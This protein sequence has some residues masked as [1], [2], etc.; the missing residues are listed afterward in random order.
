MKTKNQLFM[1]VVL[2]TIIFGCNQNNFTINGRI[3]NMS[4]GKMVLSYSHLNGLYQNDTVQ[5]RNG[6]FT[7]SGLIDKPE[8]A[9][10]SNYNN[11]IWIEPG[12]MQIELDNSHLDFIRMT[13]SKTQQEYEVYKKSL[14][15]LKES[16]EEFSIKY[17]QTHP[18]SFISADLLIPLVTMVSAPYDSLQA[19]Y[20]KLDPRAKNGTDGHWIQFDLQKQYSNQVGKPA[21]DFSVMDF[22][23]HSSVTLSV[24]KEKSVVL[25]DFW[26]G[27]CVP[28]RRSFKTTLRPLYD[29]FHQKG[30]EIIAIETDYTG[31]DEPACLK[32]IQ[33]DSISDWYHIKAAEKL[34]RNT[35]TEKDIYSKYFVWQIPRKILIDKNGIIVFNVMGASEETE[36][37]L[38]K[39]VEELMKQ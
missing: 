12:K 33:T 15:G 8:A 25:L 22:I 5:V 38:V 37:L 9:S 35:I 26:A 20:D 7:F 30:F 2:L 11:Q 3:K 36:N 6:Q 21:P 32:A 29:R 23:H 28:C 31:R 16:K 18:K 14:I 4:V 10:I 39:K 13:G 34:G 1:L 19:W 24:F 27:Y 17:I